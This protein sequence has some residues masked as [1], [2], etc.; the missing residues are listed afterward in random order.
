MA[1]RDAGKRERGNV[2]VLSEGL[3]SGCNRFRGLDAEIGCAFKPVEHAGLVARFHHAIGQQ[4]ELLVGRELENSLGVD[5]V[6]G[7]AERQAAFER[8]LF[9]GQVRRNVP[10]VG[11]GKFADRVG[12]STRQV[13]NPPLLRAIMR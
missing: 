11:N 7:K 8:K 5:G 12:R 13:V 1:L 4:G 6:G 9:S 10:G 2:V 3:R